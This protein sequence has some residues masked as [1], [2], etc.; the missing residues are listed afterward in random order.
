MTRTADI[1]MTAADRAAVA[2]HLRADLMLS[3]HGAVAPYCGRRSAA[4]YY[5]S[6][7]RL[8]FPSGMSVEDT[9]A[10]A[11]TDR[12]VW[13][14]LQSRHRHQ[15]QHLAR[16]LKQSFGDGGA[17]D[18]VTVSGL[19]LAPLMGADLPAVMLELGCFHPA[20]APDPQTLE[21]QLEGYAQSIA[22]AIE[23]AVIELE[24]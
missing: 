5:H 19:P 17:F 1:A 21:Q 2:N 8:S 18:D 12:A 4:V 13:S 6:D 15:S 11:D 24:R 10:Q 23:T 14:K 16:T 22:A 9:L 3:L 20:T 7:E